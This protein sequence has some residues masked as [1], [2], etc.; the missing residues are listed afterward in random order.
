MTNAEKAEVAERLRDWCSDP[1]AAPLAHQETQIEQMF[2]DGGKGR[3]KIH[4]VVSFDALH[5]LLTKETSVIDPAAVPGLL[6]TIAL[7]AFQAGNS[8]APDIHQ[9]L[10]LC[11]T[12]T[13]DADL[14]NPPGRTR[15]ADAAFL[16]LD[17]S[18]Q[19]GEEVAVRTVAA[20]WDKE[21]EPDCWSCVVNV[22]GGRRANVYC[23]FNGNEVK[24][25]WAEWRE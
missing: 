6:R 17:L 12:V 4:L 10:G 11:E 3:P 19:L 23:R 9:W 15:A 8:A 22:G 18:E 7:R 13:P 25:I 16:K 20:K 14:V 5:E 2:M 1:A 24:K 21:Y